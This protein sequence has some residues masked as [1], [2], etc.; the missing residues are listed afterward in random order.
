MVRIKKARQI[1]K[2]FADDTRIRIINL[3]DKEPLNVT[4]LCSIIGAAQ[5]N[6][7]KH[8]ARLRLTGVVTDKRRGFNVYYKLTRPENEKHQNL[9]NLIVK[10]LAG[11]E[12][13]RHDLEVL[14]RIKKERKNNKGES[15]GH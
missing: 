10:G 6:I 5:S 9:V 14:K 4:E 8:L 2:S 11:V 7:S 12:I 15:P 3:L 1:L 13:T